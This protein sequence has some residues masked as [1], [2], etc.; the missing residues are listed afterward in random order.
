[1][2]ELILGEAW[3][4]PGVRS[5]YESRLY[6]EFAG[7]LQVEIRQLASGVRILIAFSQEGWE[8]MCIATDHVSEERKERKT[9]GSL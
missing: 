8:S 5:P 2:E 6:S 1:V 7:I 9:Y 3:E 4:P